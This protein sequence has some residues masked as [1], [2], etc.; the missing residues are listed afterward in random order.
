M[1]DAC[2]KTAP[3]KAGGSRE[4]IKTVAQG[5]PWRRREIFPLFPSR[6]KAFLHVVRQAFAPKHRFLEFFGGFFAI[7]VPRA[8][9]LVRRGDF[10]IT[11]IF[12]LKIL[13]FVID[14]ST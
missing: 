6:D 13:L 9:S 7:I 2:P 1:A 12:K 3:P 5:D 11:C 8:K 14:F 4:E 10:F